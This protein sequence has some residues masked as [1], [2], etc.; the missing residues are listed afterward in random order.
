MDDALK[1]QLLY[2]VEDPY[3]SE[4]RYL[5]VGYMGLT[6]RDLIDHLM[7]WYGSI[8]AAYLKANESRINKSFYRTRPIHVFFQRIDD[9]VQYADDRKN[10]FME[11]QILQMAFHSV[12][13]T[14][15]Y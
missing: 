4:L 15:M 5:Y 7:D 2:S 1:T 13:A 14:G 9:D 11:K 10:P 12:N 8:I 6:T 3:V